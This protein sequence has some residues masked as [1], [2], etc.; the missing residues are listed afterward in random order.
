MINRI[1]IYGTLQPG[2]PNHHVMKGFRGS[3]TKA[4]VTGSLKQEGWGAKQGCPGIVLGTSSEA[5]E[6]YVFQ[7]E[8][9][10][11]LLPVLD[12]LEG[13]DYV[14]VQTI[15]SLESGDQVEAHIYALL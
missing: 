14:R 11:D 5:V 9:I 6:G 15:A 1:F 4:T 3:W 12:K 10:Q 7:T 13:E 8:Q 2:K